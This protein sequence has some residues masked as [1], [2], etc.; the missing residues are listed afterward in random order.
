MLTEKQNDWTRCEFSFYSKAWK[1]G[2]MYDKRSVNLWMTCIVLLVKKTKRFKL[3]IVTQLGCLPNIHSYLHSQLESILFI[4]LPTYI[5]AFRVAGPLI[6]NSPS[7]FSLSS[8][9][10]HIRMYLWSICI[11]ITV[12]KIHIQ[13]HKHISMW[14]FRFFSL[15]ESLSNFPDLC[16]FY[17]LYTVFVLLF[18]FL[19]RIPLG[20]FSFI[21]LYP[22]CLIWRKRH[23]S[24]EIRESSQVS[25]TY[26]YIIYYKFTHIC[27]VLE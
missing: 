4:P 8:F 3:W 27:S 19:C 6:F 13:A 1:P 24:I 21:F 26:L 14:N 25:R 15:S 17:I 12:R 9:D 22:A 11:L 5:P 2:S 16:W 23:L 7:D 18:A 10:L 20:Q